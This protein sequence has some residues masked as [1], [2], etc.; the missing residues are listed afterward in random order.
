MHNKGTTNIIDIGDVQIK[1]NLSYKFVLK[2]VR[3]VVGLKLNLILVVILDENG[4]YGNFG[5]NN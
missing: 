1:T 2:N 4:F 5:A 3:Y